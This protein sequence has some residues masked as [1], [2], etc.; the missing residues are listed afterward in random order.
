[1][2]RGGNIDSEN[3]ICIDL[4]SDLDKRQ[5]RRA[6]RPVTDTGAVEGAM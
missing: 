3:V 1:M 4:P 6:R 5:R 2:V